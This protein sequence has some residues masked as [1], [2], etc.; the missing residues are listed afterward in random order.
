MNL[1]A[2]ISTTMAMAHDG[3]Q[4][5]VL[6]LELTAE[7]VGSLASFVVQLIRLIRICIRIWSILTG[8][9]PAFVSNGHQE[10]IPQCSINFP[11]MAMA[12]RIQQVVSVLELIAEV[13]GS[14]ASFVVQLIRLIRIFIRIWTIWTARQPASVGN[15]YQDDIPLAGNDEADADVEAEAEAEADATNR[16]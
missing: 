6:V 5:V 2:L 3:I 10:D 1:K 13:V 14:L 9:Q 4:Q 15:S 7:V 8:R 11:Y 16:K 12:D